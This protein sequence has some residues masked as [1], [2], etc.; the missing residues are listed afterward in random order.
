M[1]AL[2]KDNNQYIFNV[3]IYLRLSRE[4]EGTACE[5]ESISNQKDYL[6]PHV[7]DQGWNLV[8]IFID[9]GYTGTNFNR[10]GFQRLLKAIEEG[11][12]NLVI[13][14]DLSRLG[15]DYIETGH[16][17]ERYF[18]QNNVRFIALNDGIDTF[19]YGNS[20]NDMSPF[21][22]VMND[23][24]ARDISK[25]VRT[26]MNSKR[27][28]GKFIGAFAPY[29]YLK[30]PQD[31]N[32]LVIDPETAPIVKR[33]FEMY[34][35]GSGYAHI[36]ANLNDLGILCPSLYK[37]Q[38]TN[39]KPN[40]KARLWAAE[41]IK[42]LL[43]NPTYAGNLTQN[44]YTTISYK[45]KKLRIIPRESWLTIEDTHEPIVTK[46]TFKLA[47]QLMATKTVGYNNDPKVKHL[48]GGLLYCADC[49]SRMTFTKTQKGIWYCI[50]ATNKR[51]RECSRHSYIEKD[52]EEYVLNALKRIVKASEVN[53]EAILEEGPKAVKRRKKTPED[54]LAIELEVTEKRL[55]EIKRSIKTLYTDKLK[56]ILSEQDF[57]DLSK[58]FN[59]EREKLIKK[60]S[61][62]SEVQLQGKESQGINEDI[63]QII[64]DLLLDFEKASRNVFTK[65][66]DR[67]EV[68][69][70][71]RLDIRYKFKA[72]P[73][74]QN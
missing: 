8:D 60:R 33:I 36:A 20:N 29:G 31:K 57:I 16:Y 74:V 3:G 42:W 52:L 56:G 64:K 32:Q 23:F 61:K 63:L 44:K 39:F 25:K 55:E 41:T 58:D 67:I 51:F 70:D 37:A 5:S 35:N 19:Q 43:I 72:S 68:S 26:S 11:K 65:L 59:E 71:K 45:V 73:E 69:E 9:D 17:L 62:L 13:V 22:S 38:K 21:K 6:L 27:R 4:D 49:G 2:N 12:I 66:I 46:E 34:V 18:P 7:I 10:P 14:K 54:H 50:C 47:Q 28:S 15:R 1:F 30:S 53:R 24:Y 48:L 40:P